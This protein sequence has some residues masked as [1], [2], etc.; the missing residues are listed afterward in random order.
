MYVENEIE[1]EGGLKGR[2]KGM[3][4]EGMGEGMDGMGMEG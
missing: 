4:M 3:G 1:V 2:G